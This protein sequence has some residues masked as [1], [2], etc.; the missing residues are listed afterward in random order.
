MTGLSLTCWW[1]C[2]LPPTHQNFK[3]LFT[4]YIL[5][6]FTMICI[7]FFGLFLKC[8]YESVKSSS[9]W[10]KLNPIRVYLTLMTV[11]RSCPRNTSAASRQTN[12]PR[13]NWIHTISKQTKNHSHNYHEQYKCIIALFKNAYSY[14]KWKKNTAIFTKVETCGPC[15][16]FFPSIYLTGCCP[17]EHCDVQFICP[18]KPLSLGGYETCWSPLR[19]SG[20][21]V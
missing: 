21:H 3:W 20:H 18:G 1:R 10:C 5:Y 9:H 8:W 17:R 11:L 6:F 12:K 14:N 7:Y 2:S 4:F 13:V 16:H 19:V 15:L